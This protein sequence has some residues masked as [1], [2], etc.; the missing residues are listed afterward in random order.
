MSEAA[1]EIVEVAPRDG[2]QNEP[3]AFTTTQK[4]A[5]IDRLVEAGLRR[6]EAVS[7]VSPSR[8][9]QMADAEAVLRA[10]PPVAGVTHVGLV[11]NERGW[12]RAQAAGC[13]EINVSLMASDTFN[14]RNQ[15]VGTD[16][17]IAQWAAI[18]DAATAARVRATLTIG[19]AFG[20]PFE[21]EIA[22]RRLVEVATAAVAAARPAELALADTIGV[23]VP[24]DV[25]ERLAAI[26]AELPGVRLR[27]HFHN[28][29]NTGLANALAAVEAGVRIVDA[30][31][32]GIGGCPFAPRAT[33]NIPTEDVAYLLARSGYATGLDLDRLAAAVRWLEAELGHAVPG[34]YAKAGPFPKPA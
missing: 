20:C 34:L 15:G 24:R 32:G 10:L 17:S 6:I 25:R 18:A 21:G 19:A 14:R 31:L 12:A 5:L 29:R 33:G 16:A 7:F 9:P 2:L 27:V 26:G 28:T 1:V 23:A 4:L 11:L 3:S 13:R 8:V 22:V 30:S